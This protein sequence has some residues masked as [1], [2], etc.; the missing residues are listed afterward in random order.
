MT[1]DLSQSPDG[2]AQVLSSPLTWRGAFFDWP[3]L[4]SNLWLKTNLSKLR[5]DPCCYNPLWELGRLDS[6]EVVKNNIC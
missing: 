1:S 2:F 5:T 3:F 6:I 4:L